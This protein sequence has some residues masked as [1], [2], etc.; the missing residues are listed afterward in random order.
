MNDEQNP[1]ILVWLLS[2]GFFL[3]FALAALAWF[4]L[5]M[6]ELISALLNSRP[7]VSFDKGSTY[8]LGAGIGGVLFVIGGVMQGLLR[9]NLAPK[10]EALFAKSLI[11]SLI[12]MFGFPH[13]THYVVASYTQKKN[14]RICSDATYRWLLYSKF[15]Y[16]KNSMVCN[17]L[18]EQKKI[19]KSSSGR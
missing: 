4:I 10:A 14:Y 19:T 15:Y 17:E 16:T 13:I 11:F 5:S 6:S 9:K 3:V 1:S 8:M 2:V 12:L 18:T 7:V